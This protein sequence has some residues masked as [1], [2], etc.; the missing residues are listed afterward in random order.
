VDQIT[1]EYANT[2]DE[3]GRLSLPSKIR[4]V[5]GTSLVVTKGAGKDKFLW[6]FQADVWESL[7][8]KLMAIASPFSKKA[9]LIQRQIIAPKVEIEIDKVGRI[10]VPQMLRHYAALSKEW[11]ILGLG[12]RIEIWDSERYAAY[13]EASSDEYDAALLELESIIL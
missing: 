12:N 11:T 10:A 4:G 13:L 7:Y 2:L 9:Q 1:G 6:C 5:L 8:G 3:K